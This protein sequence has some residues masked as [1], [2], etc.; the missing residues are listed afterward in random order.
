M[1]T[2][3]APAILILLAPAWRPSPGKECRGVRRVTTTT[4]QS[5][6][7]VLLRW[8]VHRVGGQ[9]AWFLGGFPIPYLIAARSDKVFV[10][11]KA[12]LP[13]L[14]NCRHH[15]RSDLRE[16]GEQSRAGSEQSPSHRLVE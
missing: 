5:L 2:R 8:V 13:T 9:I 10:G 4:G 12:I 7:L 1:D 15:G 6:S 16:E 11:K 14:T 3:D